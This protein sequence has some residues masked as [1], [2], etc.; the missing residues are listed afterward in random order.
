MFKKKGKNFCIRHL[1]KI[2]VIRTKLYRTK[3]WFSF[4]FYNR[5]YIEKYFKSYLE[6][7]IF[8]YFKSLLIFP[9]LQIAKFQGLARIT[10]PLEFVYLSIP[11]SC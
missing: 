7:E 3:I 11:R 2:S 8:Q 9:N 4:F 5:E 6:Y 10:F 1:I